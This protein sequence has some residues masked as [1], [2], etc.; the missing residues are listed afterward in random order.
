[1]SK[2]SYDFG[3][4]S[5]ESVVETI[6][7]AP[8]QGFEE[9]TPEYLAAA[10]AVDACSDEVTEANI[11]AHLDVLSEA[12]AEFSLFEAIKLATAN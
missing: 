1:M 10:Y 6:N 8:V 11:E 5:L 9:H 12:G 7:N 4:S 2:P 3:Y